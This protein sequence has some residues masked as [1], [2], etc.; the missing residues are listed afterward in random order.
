MQAHRFRSRSESWVATQLGLILLFALA[1]HVGPVWPAP[2]AFH[3][4]AIVAALTG[5]AVLGHSAATLGSSL[6]PLP[7][8]LPAAQLV[9]SGA[10]ALVRHPIYFG[11]L[12][13]ACG[14]AL[15]SVSSLRMLLTL[16][17]A[18][19][20]D[21]KASREE[22]WLEERYAEYP[23]YRARTKKLLPWIY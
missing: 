8:P 1:P 15:W 2:A 16:V 11:V 4:I 6:T 12:L 18:L 23:A 17:L 13:A 10:Y 3:A 9:T 5:I 14:V 7:R 19:F 21:R 22:S 20:F